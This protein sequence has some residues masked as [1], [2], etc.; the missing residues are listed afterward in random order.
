MRYQ[1]IGIVTMQELDE[2][3]TRTG[4]QGLEFGAICLGPHPMPADFPHL[5]LSFIKGASVSN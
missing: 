3:F 1:T 5:Y 2:T 4:D